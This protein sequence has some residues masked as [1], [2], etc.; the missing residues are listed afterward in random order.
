MQASSPGNAKTTRSLGLLGSFGNWCSCGGLIAEPG[1]AF[2]R[3]R[4]ELSGF[5]HPNMPDCYLDPVSG[6]HDTNYPSKPV[7][8]IV[9]FSA[10]RSVDLV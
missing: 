2:A 10:G 8:L 5:T 6:H 9:P 7:R 1:N 4:T 3:M